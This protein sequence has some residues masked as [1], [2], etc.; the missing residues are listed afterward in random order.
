MITPGK[1]A[2]S[3]LGTLINSLTYEDEFIEQTVTLG[4]MLDE[5]YNELYVHKGVDIEF[6]KKL[7][8]N[9]EIVED[10]DY[11]GEDMDFQFEELIAPRN[12]QQV[13]V[14][15]FIAGEQDFADNVNDPRLFVVKKPGFG[16]M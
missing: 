1:E 15:N 13:D 3:N 6:L 8:I 7:L 4:L 12:E 14:I 5:K 16:K 10:I 2:L 11:T 9:V